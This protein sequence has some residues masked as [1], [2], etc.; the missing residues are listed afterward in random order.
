LLAKL[1][2]ETPVEGRVCSVKDTRETVDTTDSPWQ[3]G[4]VDEDLLRAS[5][6]DLKAVQLGLLDAGGCE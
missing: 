5:E 2:Q 6:P 4:R 1:N 3:A